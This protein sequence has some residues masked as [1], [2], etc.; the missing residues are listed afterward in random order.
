MKRTIIFICGIMG[1]ILFIT[2]SILGGL[3]IEGY[4]VVSQYISES[5][6]TGLPNTDYLR[7][8]FVASGLLLAVFAFMATSVL[9]ASKSVR[10]GFI[11]FGIFY[12][13][14]TITTGFFP[15]DIGCNPDPQDATL[16]QFIHNTAGFL[17]YSVVPFC[18]I[19]I[20]AASRKWNGVLNISA[21]S[22]VCGA[23]SLVF[24]LL[25]FGNL[26][27]P[28]IGLFQRIIE[29][30]ILFWVMRTAFKLLKPLDL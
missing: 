20:G 17:V 26:T 29:G 7:Y 9:P 1:A 25:L 5:Y 8:M 2:A 14:G 24:V 13:L 12:G 28:M 6:A 10:V 11:I 15:C 23:V 22:L 4:S 3:Q 27:G 19:G 18:L 16:S 21:Y 30:A